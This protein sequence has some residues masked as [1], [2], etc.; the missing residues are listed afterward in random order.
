MSKRTKNISSKVSEG[1]LSDVFHNLITREETQDLVRASVSTNA[2]L[3]D[4]QL[5]P[6]SNEKIGF[7]GSHLRLTVNF[8]RTEQN[9]MQK[10]SFFV[11]TLP[12]DV[13]S[14]AAYIQEKGCIQKETK[15]FEVLA[16]L[17]ANN[18]KGEDWIPKC[19]LAKHDVMVFQDLKPEGFTNR[20][21]LLDEKSVKVAL[22]CIA[23]MHASSM[24]AEDRIQGLH[25]HLLL[26]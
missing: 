12:F 15:F 24:I 8:R 4:Y 2:E 22:G 14:Q 19:Y 13:P 10:R 18:F 21:R 17:L 6:Y 23:R 20:S 25:K 3:L 9:E 16:P 26:Q 5:H 7:L 11:K 1:H